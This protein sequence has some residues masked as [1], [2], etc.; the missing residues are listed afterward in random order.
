[1]PIKNPPV[2]TNF[3][4]QLDAL[5][6]RTKAEGWDKKYSIDVKSMEAALKIHRGAKQKD[7]ELRQLYEQHHKSFAVAQSELYRQYMEALGI[8]RAAHRSQPEVMRSLDVFK[9]KGGGSRRKKPA[10]T[11]SAAPQPTGPEATASR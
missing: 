11:P 9:R 1:M 2:P 6:T 4:D 7:A 8:L 3:D 5:L 10:A